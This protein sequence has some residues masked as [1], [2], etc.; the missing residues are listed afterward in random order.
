MS[1][2]NDDEDRDKKPNVIHTR[3]P[4]DLDAEIKRRANSLG[5]SVSNLVRNVLSHAFGLVGDIVADGASVARTARGAVS[6]VGVTPPQPPQ[7]P[8]AP[9]VLG[10][11]EALLALNAVCA[12]CNTILKKGTPAAI[13]VPGGNAVLCKRCLKEVLDVDQ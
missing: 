6:P 8:P 2:S 11:Q 9:P 5:V 12:R 3:V 7:P 13:A 10:W 4:E 1:A